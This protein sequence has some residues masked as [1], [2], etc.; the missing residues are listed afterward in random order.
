[1]IPMVIMLSIWCVLRIS[2][3]TLMVWL[4]QDITVVFTAYPV[5]WGLSCLFFAYFLNRKDWL[6]HGPEQ[7]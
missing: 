6:Y 2:Y 4:F 5:T 3:I 1:M 7:L